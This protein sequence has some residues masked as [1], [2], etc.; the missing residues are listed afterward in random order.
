MVRHPSSHTEY[1][2]KGPAP[3]QEERAQ[4]RT[5]T[6]N[7]IHRLIDTGLSISEVHANLHLVCARTHE[8]RAA[9][10]GEEV[11]ERLAVRHVD[12]AEPHSQL[13]F[14]RSEQVVRAQ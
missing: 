1:Q 6:K 8:M 2:P 12:H 7:E 4:E 13:G 3:H 9:E 10:R 5:R 14:A 11:I